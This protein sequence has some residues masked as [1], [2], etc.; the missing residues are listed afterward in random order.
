[1]TRSEQLRSTTNLLIALG[2]ALLLGVPALSGQTGGSQSPSQAP[3]NSQP[4]QEIPDAPSTVQPPPP[5]PAPSPATP[6]DAGPAAKPTPKPS[7]DT[8]QQ[9]VPGNPAEK[10]QPPAQAAPSGTAPATTPNAAGPTNQINPTEN[11]YKIS[12]STNFVQIPVMV[13]DG[14]GRRV[15]GLLPKDFVVLENG[16]KQTLSYFTSDPFELS[17]AILLDL[18]MADVALQK[19]NQTYGSL[20]GAFSPYDEIALY[21]YSSTVSQVADFTGRP[22]RLTA[23]LDQMKLVR[24]HS[25][26]PPVMGGPLAS[27]PS[28]LHPRNRMF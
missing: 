25:N 24:G 16:K 20:I 10:P 12:V 26:G 11:L 27:G 18:G 23:S 3:A 22:E 13:K 19:I 5:K 2:I 14:Q 7:Y 6:P 1:M 15:D 17:V 28:T 8:Y 9:P 21:T 4:A